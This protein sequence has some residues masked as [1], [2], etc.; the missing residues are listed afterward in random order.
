MNIEDV[1]VKKSDKGLV[2]SLENIQFKPDSAVLLES[3]MIKLK[4]IGEVLKQFSQNDIL[5]TGHT[6]MAGNAKL[7]QKLSEQRAQVVADY[8][9]KLGIKDAYH[10]FTK[11]FGATQPVA[12]NDTEDGK[13]K[14]RRVEIIIMDK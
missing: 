8:L 1:S 5:V 11:G 13:A 7:R 3:E 14:N 9:I 12:S 10:I 4:K 6:A 2:I